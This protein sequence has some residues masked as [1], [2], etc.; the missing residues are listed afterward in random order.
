MIWAKVVA[1]PWPWLIVPR[2]AIA[3]AGRVHPDFAGIEHAEAENV[4]ILDRPGA[5]DLGEDS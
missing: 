4:A 1:W 3:A 2:R 5:D